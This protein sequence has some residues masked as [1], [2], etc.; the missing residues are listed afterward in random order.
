MRKIPPKYKPLYNKALARKS[1][2]AA[3]RSFCLECMAYNTKEITN[4]T[5]IGCPLYKY[6]ESG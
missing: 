6:R 5:D 1:R 3:I 4:C 2:K